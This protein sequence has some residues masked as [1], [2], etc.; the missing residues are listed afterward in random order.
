MIKKNQRN[1]VFIANHQKERVIFPVLRK[2][3]IKLSALD[4]IDE[5]E[6]IKSAR[7]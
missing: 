5:D 2:L 3:E 1:T 6:L 4:S 7:N